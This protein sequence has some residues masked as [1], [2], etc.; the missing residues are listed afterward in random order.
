MNKR[1]LA[2]SAAAVAVMA[3][4]GLAASASPAAANRQRCDILQRASDLYAEVMDV[5]LGRDY[6]TWNY[7]YSRWLDVE[8]DLEA[9]GC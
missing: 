3:G 8:M 1:R 2:L 5:T 6:S 7:A 9:F 4:V